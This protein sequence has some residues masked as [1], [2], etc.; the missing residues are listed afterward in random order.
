MKIVKF[1]LAALIAVGL[2]F[3]LAFAADMPSV[4]KGKALFNDPKLGGGTSGSSCNSCHPNGGKL[5]GGKKEYVTPAP[6]GQKK[7]H[8]TLEGA[9]NWCIEMALKGKAIKNDS[10]EMKSLVMYIGSLG[11]TPAKGKK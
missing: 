2:A 4:E 1:M 3:P 10:V 6:G 11:K 8:K 7:T 9:I 5:T